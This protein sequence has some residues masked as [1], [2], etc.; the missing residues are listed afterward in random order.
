MRKTALPLLIL[1]VCMICSCFAIA[2]NADTLECIIR[3]EDVVAAPDTDVTMQVVVENNPGI[4]NAELIVSF[5]E[6]LSLVDA[7]AGDAFSALTYVEPSYYRNPTIFVWDSEQLYDEDIKDGVILTLTFHVAEGAEGILPVKIS[8]ESGL[9][10]DQDLNEMELTTIDGSINSI[11][12]IPGDADGNDK[13]ATLDIT[14]IRRWISDGR[15]TDPNGYNV[16]INQNASDVDGNGKIATLD[17]TK[18]RRWISDGRKTDPNGY[19]IVLLPGKMAC[20]HSMTYTAANA[21]TCTEPGNTE[22][23][24]CSLCDKYFSDAEG[25]YEILYK[26]TQLEAGHSYE[27]Q[28]SYD[29][30]SHWHDAACE[31]KEQPADLTDHTFVD[32]KCSVCDAAETVTV[33][34]VDRE[35]TVIDT[36]RVPYGT[37]AAAPEVPA[38]LGY[39]FKNWNGSFDAVTED[40]T[41]A[42]QY[43][44]A[45]VVTFADTDG[46]VLK[47]ES[48]EDGGSATAYV[49]SQEDVIPEGYD[50]VGWDK[51][52]D[53]IT[54]DTVVYVNYV[55]KTYSV[56]FYMPDGTLLDTQSVEHGSHAV[57]PDCSEHYFDWNALKMGSFSGWSASL[58]G[59]KGDA[60][61]YAQ[62]NNE[63][64]QPV[65][66]IDTTANSASIKMYA[67]E[68]CYLYAIDFGFDWTGNISILSCDK[69]IAS[70]LYKGN[71]GA[72]NIDFNNKYNNFHYT[73]TNAAGVKLEGAYTTVLDIRFMTDGNQVVNKDVL[74]LF[75]ECSII[76]SPKQT[77]NMDELETVTP[78]IVI[79]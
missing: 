30:S 72:S 38:L 41:I 10:F 9:I 2:A 24:Y 61:I 5:G 32:H 15:K 47:Q 33:T 67:P 69:N 36:Q 42:A 48:V 76:Y 34:F 46:T 35:G 64:T 39:V 43:A 27:K 25:K 26:N 63:Y 55:K 78:I 71:T 49:F 66:S 29:E 75:E 74:K 31:H 20:T 1:C 58:E 45:H 17:I 73:W 50:R 3:G 40:V 7:K 4:S 59:I 6:G 77:S 56:S 14:A 12:Y 44:K 8:Y 21:P 54:E 52:F 16:T 68:G 65:I 22:Y 23:W 62:Y 18:I 70:N 60:A 51:P 11:S 28:W 79:K 57:A 13:V 37:A 53:N 19:N